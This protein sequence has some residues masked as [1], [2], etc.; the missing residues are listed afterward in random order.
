MKQK[1]LLLLLFTSNIIC[2]S[3]DIV[4]GG[5]NSWILHTP[6]DT[7]TSL[8]I[9]PLINNIYDFNYQTT[10][11][12]NGDVAFSGNV[13][14]GTSI[15]SNL[16]GW[17]KVLDVSGVN[18]SKILATSE[19]ALYKVGVFS[20]NQWYSGGGFVGTESN[21]PLHLITNYNVKMSILT[22]GNIGIGTLNPTS[23]LTVAGNIASREVTVT[24]DAGADF[25]FENDYELPTLESVDKYIKE[26][27][28]LPEVASAYEMKKNGINL[29]EMNIKL[30]Q[31]IEEMTLYM[32]EIK[33]ENAEMKNKQIEFEKAILKLNSTIR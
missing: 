28:H 9:A 18:G 26:N 16:Q 7:R 24:V 23:K 1:L 17:N 33:K 15:P 8:H 13:G 32:I 29:S 20:H 2:F 27:K 19:N 5:I 12:N 3:Q 11:S 21:H 10:F 30:L 31:K 22:N 14:V 6:D 25:V 4:S